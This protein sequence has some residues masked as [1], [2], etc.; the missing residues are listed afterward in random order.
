MESL[1]VLSIL[2]GILFGIITGLVPGIHINLVASILLVNFVFLSTFAQIQHIIIFIIAMGTTHSFVD[3]IPSV[4]FGVP[5]PDTAMSVLPAHQLVLEGKA[6]KAIFLSSI[7]SLC[8]MFFSYVTAPLFFFSLETVYES[9]K[10]YIPY[11]LCF[12][13][14]SLVLLEKKPIKIF[15]ACIII[16]FS[17][18][19]GMLVLNTSM[20]DDPLLILFSGLFGTA[21]IYMSL[22]DENSRFPKQDFSLGFKVDRYFLKSIAVGGVCSTVC[23]ISPGIGNAQAGTLAALFF[24]KIEAETF[25]VVV[26]AINTINFILSFLTFYLIDRAR[27]GSV[28]VISQIVDTISLEDMTIYFIVIFIVAILSLFITL[29][30]GKFFIRTIEKI[31]FKIINYSILGFLILLIAYMT[32]FYGLLIL[33]ASTFLGILCVS[34]NVRRVHLMAVLLVPVILNLV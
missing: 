1:I 30:I 33:I 5:S 11:V 34:V 16:S 7:G 9:I 25:I 12:A 27:N 8:G 6:Y 2:L 4:L 32:G 17:G 20:I 24:R 26:S 31:N 3:F 14:I 10:A 29:Y 28:F 18:G 22:K 19:L 23:S 13:L 21:A 15:W